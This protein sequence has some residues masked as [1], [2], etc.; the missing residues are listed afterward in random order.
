MKQLKIFIGKYLGEMSLTGGVG[1]SVYSI[2]N[3]SYETR[4]GLCRHGVSCEPIQGVAYYY[5]SDVILM[6]STGAMLII[7][8]ILI[9]KNK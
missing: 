7:I 1:L 5:Y 2:F 8:G 9:I 4:L 6:I 3:F